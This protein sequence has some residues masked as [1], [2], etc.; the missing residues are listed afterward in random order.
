MKVKHGWLTKPN[1]AAVA[2]LGI[3]FM[4]KVCS[5]AIVFVRIKNGLL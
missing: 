1:L 3:S 5:Q 2:E 4:E